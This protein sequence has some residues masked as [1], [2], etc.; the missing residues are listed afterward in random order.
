MRIDSRVRGLPRTALFL[1]DLGRCFLSLSGPKQLEPLFRFSL[2]IGHDLKAFDFTH[3]CT[4]S[5]TML[6]KLTRVSQQRE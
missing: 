1:G 2:R 6:M 5:T 4:S 3:F